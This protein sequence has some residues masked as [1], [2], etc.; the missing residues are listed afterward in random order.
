MVQ[1]PSSF[2]LLVYNIDFFSPPSD[3]QAWH[4]PT[5]AARSSEINSV[6]LWF[7]AGSESCTIRDWILIF[8]IF[9]LK[10][11]KKANFATWWLGI[12]KAKH[13][14]LQMVLYN[15]NSCRLKNKIKLKSNF[16][17]HPYTKNIHLY[18]GKSA[19][20]EEERKPIF[21]NETHLWASP[22]QTFIN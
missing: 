14:T 19:T 17:V 13:R 4:I 12:L 2:I 6:K 15:I 11:K 18:V 7:L 8:S 21:I 1:L 5:R 9:S 10:K 22:R 16:T 20:W 3:K